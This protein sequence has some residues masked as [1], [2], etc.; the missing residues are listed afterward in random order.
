VEDSWSACLQTLE[1]HSL[2]VN[3]VVISHDSKLLT[4]ASYD[5]TVK[6]WDASSGQCLQSLDVERFTSVKSFDITNSYLETDIGTVCLS[7]SSV[8]GRGGPTNIEPASPRYEGYGISPNGTWITSKS[9]NP[10]WLPREYRPV[11]STV[12]LS[13]ICFGSGRVLL[14]TFDSLRLLQV[15]T[16]H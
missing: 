5:K 15:L 4:S 6:V 12:S 3:S 16:G 13:T 8:S 9:E 10:L 11:S 2:S 1:D 14:L 7:L